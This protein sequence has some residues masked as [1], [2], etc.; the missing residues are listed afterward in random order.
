MSLNPCP[1]TV[2]RTWA[3]MVAASMDVDV[4]VDDGEDAPN[5]PHEAPARLN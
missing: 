3:T 1:P 5:G 4:D 2:L